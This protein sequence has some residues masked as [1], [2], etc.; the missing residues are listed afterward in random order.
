MLMNPPSIEPPRSLQAQPALLADSIE[1]LRLQSWV[2]GRLD[3][4]VP[5]GVQVTG[6]TGWIH[7]PGQPCLM[8]LGTDATTTSVAAGD[9]LVVFPS[10]EHRLLEN[11]H[12][13]TI[14]IE[15]LLTSYRREPVDP[16]PPV[17]QPSFA[18]LVSLCFLLDGFERTL[19]R[20]SLPA[21][22]LLGGDGQRARPYVEDV[23][24]LILQEAASGEP[25]AQ[26]IVNRLVRVLLIKAVQEHMRTADQTGGGNWL[27]AISDPEIGR[28]IAFMHDQPE[29]P[30]TVASLA[31]R[32]ALS[33]SAFSARFTGLMGKPPLEYLFEWRMQKAAYLLR[34]TRAELKEVAAR[35]G[36]ESASAFSKAFARWS[37]TAPGSYRQVVRAQAALAAN[38][39]PI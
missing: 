30:W 6:C 29:A 21:F 28:A 13:P 3:L 7:L 11:Q 36:Y 26:V 32:V 25:C 34:T 37:G 22:I 38:A 39:P 31:E 14:P 4:H 33:R 24:R 10:H 27:R 20:A 16:L 5:W 17:P 9:L 12:S 19:L 8:T 23:L 18:S 15:R 35:V 2:L 1:A